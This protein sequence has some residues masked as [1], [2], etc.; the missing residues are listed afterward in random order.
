MH[1]K[2]EYYPKVRPKEETS[3]PRG[4]NR[5]SEQSKHISNS[6]LHHQSP[7][8]N[9]HAHTQTDPQQGFCAHTHLGQTGLN[10]VKLPSLLQAPAEPI[11]L[12]Y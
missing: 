8:S 11:M 2:C 12:K 3:V 9:P 5:C 4:M 1:V 7:T 6:H 10:K